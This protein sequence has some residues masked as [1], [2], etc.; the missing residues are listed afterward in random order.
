MYKIVIVDDDMLIR[1]GIRNVIRWKDLD[2][3][4]SGEASSGDD[5]LKVIEKVKPDIVITDIKMPNMDGIELIE[6]N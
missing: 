6:K 5:A 3:E 1:K 2:C 4:I